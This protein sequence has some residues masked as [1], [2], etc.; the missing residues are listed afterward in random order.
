MTIMMMM[1]RQ[2]KH[3]LSQ[4]I[5]KLHIHFSVTFFRRLYTQ[6]LYNA[7]ISTNF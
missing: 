7:L 2:E 4:E 1:A 5:L 6:L 3:L